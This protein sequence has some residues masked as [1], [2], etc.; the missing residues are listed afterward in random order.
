MTTI[1]IHTQKVISKS[2]STSVR[3]YLLSIIDVPMGILQNDTSNSIKMIVEIP[4]ISSPIHRRSIG[5]MSSSGN[6]KIDLSPSKRPFLNAVN[7][8]PILPLPAPMKPI[9]PAPDISR[10]K[11]KL[12][13]RA[14][15]S[16]SNT[17]QIRAVEALTFLRQMAMNRAKILRSWKNR[18]SM[19]QKEYSFTPD[20][21]STA[22]ESPFACINSNGNAN[23]KKFCQATSFDSFDIIRKMRVAEPKEENKGD[24]SKI[25][26]K[27]SINL[28]PC[29][30]DH[31][32]SKESDKKRRYTEPNDEINFAS[33]MEKLAFEPLYH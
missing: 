11:P 14:L 16:V 1:E 8:I 13:P 21:P 30:E 33:A 23:F 10:K 28:Y 26:K 25:P 32:I 2:Q 7:T 4:T 9:E 12:I 3:K 19:Y 27:L 6:K 5:K 29:S 31:E 17:H 22:N 18:N 15:Y 24:F 20:S